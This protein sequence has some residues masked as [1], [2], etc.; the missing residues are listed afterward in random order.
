[1]HYLD[2]V[3]NTIKNKRVIEAF[4]KIDRKDFLPDEVKH[5]SEFDM[6]IHIMDGQTASQPSLIAYML[7]ELDIKPGDKVL[8]IGAGSGFVTALLSY[9]VGKNGKVYAIEIN[10]R[11]YEFAKKNLKKYPFTKNVE[12]ILGSGYF[13]YDK[14]KPYDKIYVGA[15]P[16]EIPKELI[17]QLKVGGICVIPVGVFDQKLVKIIKRNDDKIEIFPLMDVAF[18]PLVKK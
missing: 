4:E 10:P 1:M 13:G 12:L 7:Q 14:A 6:P 8:E 15:S 3:K 11:L 17:D 9:L 2:I 16:P 18:V 5:K